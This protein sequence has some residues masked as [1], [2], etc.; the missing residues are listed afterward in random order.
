M[1]KN[2]DTK[3]LDDIHKLISTH[4]I[5]LFMKGDPENPMCG[6]SSTVVNILKLCG[7]KDFFYVNV[8]EDENI[9]Q[10]I[11]DYANWPTIPQLYISQKFIGGC[12]I[13]KEMYKDGSLKELI[14]TI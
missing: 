6:F 2:T 14:D 9:R 13:C 10:G 1:S 11:K 12:D 3:I 8:L 7:V 5:I 4:N